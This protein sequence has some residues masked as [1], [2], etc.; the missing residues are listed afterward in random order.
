MTA[1]KGYLTMSGIESK[2][3]PSPSIELWKSDSPAAKTTN[4]IVANVTAGFKESLVPVVRGVK[5]EATAIGY[6]PDSDSD[7]VMCRRIDNDGHAGIECPNCGEQIDFHAGH[8]DNGRVFVC[9]KGMPLMRE[10]EYYC[11]HCDSTVIF[12]KK[13]E[14]EGG[15]Q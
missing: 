5:R 3:I 10:A 15:R 9:E 12:L 13:C 2:P 11:R 8:I 14:P 4:A 6:T 7:S 1:G